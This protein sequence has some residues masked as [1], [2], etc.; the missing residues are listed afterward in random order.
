MTTLINPPKGISV[1]H[2]N[3][4]LK[5]TR[6]WLDNLPMIDRLMIIWL[7]FWDFVWPIILVVWFSN[8]SITPLGSIWNEP[9][10]FILS[11]FP[12]VLM[13][14]IP[15]LVT[16]V[17]IYVNYCAIALFINETVINVDSNL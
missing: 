12:D 17:T 13:L 15:F 11:L 6:K 14:P 5:I 1:H 9:T 16:I 8:F 2:E 3:G 10:S 7:C 4:Q